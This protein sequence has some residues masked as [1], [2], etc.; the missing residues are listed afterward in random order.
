M[1]IK[2]QLFF[3]SLLFSMN[4]NLVAGQEFVKR[5]FFKQRPEEAMADL[6]YLLEKTC[7]DNAQKTL[8][9]EYG[10]ADENNP[11]PTFQTTQNWLKEQWQSFYKTISENKNIF[12]GQLIKEK[13][14]KFTKETIEHLIEIFHIKYFYQ[15]GFKPSPN[16]Q[17]LIFSTNVE[18]NVSYKA[19]CYYENCKELSADLDN[20]NE[21]PPFCPS[22]LNQ[23]FDKE[24]NASNYYVYK[25]WKDRLVNPME[26]AQEIIDWNS[27]KHDQTIDQLC[28]AVENYIRATE[29]HAQLVE[30]GMTKKDLSFRKSY[31]QV[32]RT[33]GSIIRLRKQALK[34]KKFDL[35]ALNLIN[36]IH[37]SFLKLSQTIG[38]KTA[39]SKAIK[40][41]AQPIPTRPSKGMRIPNSL[42][43]TPK[44]VDPRPG[45]GEIS[46]PATARTPRRPVQRVEF[47]DPVSPRLEYDSPRSVQ[48]L[49]PAGSTNSSVYLKRGFVGRLRETI[50][51]SPKS[52]L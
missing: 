9:Q 44:L 33:R 45:N 4:L 43:Q 37:V 12:T 8:A 6:I 3:I 27:D 1:K 25:A 2:L 34:D 11:L 35:E 47:L 40:I 14:E 51:A 29:Q 30:K 19:K 31:D 26:A 50:E 18:D 16:S 23:A 32:T 7:W 49:S 38:T 21:T 42:P 10:K 13:F 48:G 39:P 17:G 41:T 36:K 20:Q 5:E 24:S 15:M 52:A 28:K 22:H 46:P